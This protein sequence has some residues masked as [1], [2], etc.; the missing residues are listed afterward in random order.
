MVDL[1]LRFRKYFFE[2]DLVNIGDAAEVN[3][4]MVFT[5]LSVYEKFRIDFDR[6]SFYVFGGV[7]ADYRLSNSIEKDFQNVFID[8][9][10][11]LFGTTAGIGFAKRIARFWRLSFDVYYDYDLTKMYESSIGNVRNNGVGFK[12]GFGPFNPKNK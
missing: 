3:N 7:R 10:S 1:S 11:F 4:S 8:S 2:Y 9:K 12:I 5:T 6:W